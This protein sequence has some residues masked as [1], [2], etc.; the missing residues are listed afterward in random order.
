MIHSSLHILGNGPL[1]T[2]VFN[3]GVFNPAGFPIV[4][5]VVHPALPPALVGELQ[6]LLAAL[7]VQTPASGR[8]RTIVLKLLDESGSMSTGVDQTRKAYNDQLALVKANA[9]EVGAE[10]TQINF[11][12][13]ARILASHAQATQLVELT[14]ANYRPLGGTALYDTVASAIKHVLSHPYAACAD[15][16]ILLYGA[17][18]GD[19]TSSREWGKGSNSGARNEFKTLMQAV[20]KNPR[21][22]VALAGP[23]VKLAQFADE[24]AVEWGNVSAFKPE[25]VASRMDAH[26]GGAHAIQNYLSARTMGAMRSVD[27][28]AG[29]A[30]HALAMS[31]L[32]EAGKF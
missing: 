8:K 5:P 9:V 28:Y 13:D 7:S 21:W 19:D 15:T 1:N 4:P 6:L 31:S 18:D 16:A 3:P 23:D 10:V 2:R 22:T 30:S 24:M 12:S 32:Q 25:S 20:R 17:T 29:T 11:S 26:V 14:P 27:M